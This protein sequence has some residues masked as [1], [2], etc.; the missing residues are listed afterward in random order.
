MPALGVHADIVDRIQ[1]H[2]VSGANVPEVR[3]TYDRYQYLPEMRAALD[4]WAGYVAKITTA[5]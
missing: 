1:N 3:G 5:K 4:T 2:K